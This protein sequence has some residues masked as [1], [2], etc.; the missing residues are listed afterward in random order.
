MLDHILKFK[1]E[2][3]KINN[4]IVENKLNLIAHNGSGF[5]SYVVLNNLAH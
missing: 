4:K 1:R 5:D 2:A 3:K